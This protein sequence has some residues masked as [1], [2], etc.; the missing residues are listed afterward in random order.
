M[1]LHHVPRPVTRGFPPVDRHCGIRNIA[2]QRIG[3]DDEGNVTAGWQ[4]ISLDSFY[5]NLELAFSFAIEGMSGVQVGLGAIGRR[6]SWLLGGRHG[7]GRC[8]PCP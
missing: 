1:G 3:Q 2:P 8:H 5:R 6:L 4:A 7:C